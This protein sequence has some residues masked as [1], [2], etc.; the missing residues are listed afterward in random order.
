MDVMIHHNNN[1]NCW[2]VNAQ[3]FETVEYDIL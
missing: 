1:N 3:N 2:A